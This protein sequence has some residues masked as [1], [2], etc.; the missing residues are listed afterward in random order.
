ME[1]EEKAT[2]GIALFYIFSL[3]LVWLTPEIIPPLIYVNADIFSASD[4]IGW[5]ISILVI[6]PSLTLALA[7]IVSSNYTYKTLPYLIRK[8]DFI[9]P[10]LFLVAALLF[11]VGISIF[12]FDSFK[13]KMTFQVSTFAVIFYLP[14]YFFKLYRHTTFEEIVKT[15]VSEIKR[16]KLIPILMNQESKINPSSKDSSQLLFSII[17][18]TVCETELQSFSFTIEEYSK[19]YISVIKELVDKPEKITLPDYAKNIS[20]SKKFFTQTRQFGNLNA[21]FNN[22]T[23]NAFDILE[24]INQHG[25]QQILTEFIQKISKATLIASK[26]DYSEP[27]PIDQFSKNNLILLKKSSQL[28]LKKGYLDSL[29]ATL[30][31]LEKL[32]KQNLLDTRKFRGASSDNSGLIIENVKEI[33]DEVV[34][35]Y[36]SHKYSFHDYDYVLKRILG[37]T[38]KITGFRCLTKGHLIYDLDFDLLLKII[39][40]NIAS[41]HRLF[42]MGGYTDFFKVLLT[43]ILSHYYFQKEK[44]IGHLYVSMHNDFIDYQYQLEQF[45]IFLKIIQKGIIYHYSKPAEWLKHILDSIDTSIQH[46]NTRNKNLLFNELIEVYEYLI[47]ISF[48]MEDY[49]LTKILVERYLNAFKIQKDLD[50]DPHYYL[51]TLIYAFIVKGLD[52]EAITLAKLAQTYELQTSNK[53]NL[54]YHLVNLA[55]QTE[56]NKATKTKNEILK[57][58][59]EL[60]QSNKE[61]A[62]QITQNFQELTGEYSRGIAFH[63]YFE[64]HDKKR[65]LYLLLGEIAEK[66][67]ITSQEIGKKIF[68]EYK[69]LKP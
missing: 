66:E 19:A 69:K 34:E 1:L 4:L 6:I 58:I 23:N 30:N 65:N 62:R 7:Q 26:I 11:G 44:N 15:L 28:A 16:E 51:S 67:L 40:S 2:I 54:T 41:G 25:N 10:G 46:N 57:M 39:E 36:A 27:C 18:K 3:A 38:A 48:Q 9:L 35:N 32:G 5:L 17:K 8:K 50:K 29:A 56:K 47:Y 33:N 31:E 60:E 49:N 61:L 20:N 53:T 13:T 45:H 52:D 42:L 22:W 64:N 37:T 43:P 21:L 55:A 14:I 24:I 63:Y 12:L 59:K 68:K